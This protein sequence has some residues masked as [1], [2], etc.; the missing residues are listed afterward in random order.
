MMTEFLGVN[1]PFNITKP[2]RM[3]IPDSWKKQEGDGHD[4]KDMQLLP[5]WHLFSAVPHSIP[6]G[7]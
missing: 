1:Y 3:R 4:K 6:E 2:G 5:S 7:N